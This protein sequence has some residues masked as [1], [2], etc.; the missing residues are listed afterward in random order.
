M[1]TSKTTGSCGVT[2]SSTNARAEAGAGTRPPI[3]FL[4]N[5]PLAEAALTELER[6]FEVIFRARTR[7]DLEQLAALKRE[8]PELRAVLASFGVILSSDLLALFEPEGII[9]I[10][11]SLLPKYRGPAPIEGAILAGETEFGVSVMK[12]SAAMDAGPVYWQTS[13]HFDEDTPKSEIY[14]QLATVAAQWLG[15]HLFD[16]PTPTAQNEAKATYTRMMKKRNAVLRPDEKSAER[17]AREVRAYAGFPKSK[18]TFGSEFDG[19]TCTILRAH[20]G[21]PQPGD[22]ALPCAEGTWLI[23]DELQPESRKAMN[24]T[25]FMNGYRR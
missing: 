21:E 23:I 18:F 11:P 13:L 3:L 17:L 20:A 5:G 1:S 14:Q 10:H 25:A 6:H 22:L 16:L 15:K 7:E 2:M 12:I 8:Q 9:N 19:V 24:A 4:G